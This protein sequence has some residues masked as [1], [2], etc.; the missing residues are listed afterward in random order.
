MKFEVVI[1]EA[2]KKETIRFKV[3]DPR[4]LTAHGYIPTW[5]EIKRYDIK[6]NFEIINGYAFPKVSN[7]I[8]IEDDQ[9]FYVGSRE[10]AEEIISKLFE[11]ISSLVEEFKEIKNSEQFLKKNTL[12]FEINKE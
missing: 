11:K 12:V 1:P 9:V 8:K 6:G 10:N 4:V 2:S 5:K 7:C 3:L